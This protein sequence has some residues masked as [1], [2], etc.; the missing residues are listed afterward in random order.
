[1]AL[2]MFASVALAQEPPAEPTQNPAVPYRLFITKNV[3]TLLKLDTRSGQL[4]Q[5]QWGDRDHRFT[6][7]LNSIALASDGK[8]GRFTLYPTSNMYTFILLDQE[9]GDAWH[10]QWGKADERFVVP[11]D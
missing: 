9:K 5:V 8:P 6:D 10:V 4:W 1:M 2:C 3:Y 7:I 11:I